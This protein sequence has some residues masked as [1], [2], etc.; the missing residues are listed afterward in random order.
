MTLEPAESRGGRTQGSLSSAA[1]R[2]SADLD[3]ALGAVLTR[4]G[5]LTSLDGRARADREV[6]PG[7]LVQKSFSLF[8][9]IV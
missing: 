6:V 4:D 9:R 1:E 5:W 3:H 2:R 8:V 7:E